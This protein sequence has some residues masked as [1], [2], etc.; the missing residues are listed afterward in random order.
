MREKPKWFKEAEAEFDEV[1]G[2]VLSGMAAYRGIVEVL[3]RKAGA[4]KE[5]AD[6]NDEEWIAAMDKVI[7]VGRRGQ[8]TADH[9]MQR[10]R[11]GPG[12]DLTV[13]QLGALV[14]E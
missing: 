13:L 12:M 6:P 8:E 5:L 3:E 1:I 2:Q 4:E 11:D 10:W 7:A 9:D 14:R